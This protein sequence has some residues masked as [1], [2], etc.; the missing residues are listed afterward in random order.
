MII[1]FVRIECLDGLR[2]RNAVELLKKP[3]VLFHEQEP[4]WTNLIMFHN[5]WKPPPEVYKTCLWL[6]C[7][8]VFR[9]WF[10]YE[11]QSIILDIYFLQHFRQGNDINVVI[12]SVEKPFEVPHMQINSIRELTDHG[13]R[14][15]VHNLS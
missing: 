5:S 15:N 13:N 7:E 10:S 14:S 4:F 6:P 3:K 8:L 9:C 12:Y 1:A 11:G 2:L